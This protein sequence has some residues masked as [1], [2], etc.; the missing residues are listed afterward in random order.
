MH[1]YWHFLC[2]SWEPIFFL[3]LE[4]F[5]CGLMSILLHLIMAQSE[6][7]LI[8]S[9]FLY[10]FDV[11]GYVLLKEV[12]TLDCWCSSAVTSQHG[13]CGFAS[14]PGLSVCMET[15]CSSHVVYRCKCDG[16]WMFVSI[17]QPRK[18]QV[19]CHGC[20][21]PLTQCPQS[22][23]PAPKGH[24]SDKKCKIMDGYQCFRG[25]KRDLKTLKNKVFN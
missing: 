23:F 14:H 17:C 19:I 13:G 25:T 12:T 16:L 11:F 4:E 10:V 15:T 22:L 21:S 8:L 18:E 6:Q 7:W 24:V 5:L 9:P 3:L 2:T 1:F 20:T